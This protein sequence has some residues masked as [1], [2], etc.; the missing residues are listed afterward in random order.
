MLIVDS[1]EPDLA[2]TGR[3]GKD[4]IDRLGYDLTTVE[5]ESAL[6]ARCAEA[7]IIHFFVHGEYDTKDPMFSCLR[8]APENGDDGRLDAY[9]VFDLGLG[10]PFVFM[11][12]CESGLSRITRGDDQIGL[13]DP[14]DLE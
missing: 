7:D 14:D 5:T 9:E 6:K 8:L 2:A 3:A 12:A 11:G 1:V 10:H 4:A 13:M